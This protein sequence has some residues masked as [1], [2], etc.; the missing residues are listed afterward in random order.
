MG[1][2]ALRCRHIKNHFQSW[3]SRQCT[4]TRDKFCFACVFY[5]SCSYTYT[6]WAWLTRRLLYG[7]SSYVT[8]VMLSSSSMSVSVNGHFKRV[9]DSIRYE[10]D[11]QRFNWTPQQLTSSQL[12][13][14]VTGW[15]HPSIQ[16]A[17]KAKC[18]RVLD[19]GMSVSRSW[20]LSPGQLIKIACSVGAEK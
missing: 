17:S 11:L 18:E 7:F 15:S 8:A 6:F 5:F 3:Q 12:Y 4:I 13:L 14:W 2:K 1:Q 19:N 20:S 10:I 16:P 9:L